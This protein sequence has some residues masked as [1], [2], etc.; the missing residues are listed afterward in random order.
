MTTLNFTIH[1]EPTSSGVS[2]WAES[3]D[4]PGFYA[5][6]DT[7]PAL[8]QRYADALREMHRLGEVESGYRVRETLGE[9]RTVYVGDGLVVRDL[10][11]KMSPG[12]SNA[13][14][15]PDPLTQSDATLTGDFELVTS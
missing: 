1:M 2:W 8:R 5:A 15:A 4:L 12:H 13:I 11:R 10:T 7:L 14:S 3:D 9:M 6:A